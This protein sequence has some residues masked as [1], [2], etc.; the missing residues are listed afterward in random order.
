MLNS[1]PWYFS[2]WIGSRSRAAMTLEERGLYRDI[3][4]LCY[5]SGSV[6]ADERQLRRL[7]GADE[8]EWR[9]AWPAVRARLVVTETGDLTHPRV[10]E[11][12]PVLLSAAAGR[13]KSSSAA[14]KARWNSIRSRVAESAGLDAPR[15]APRIP[16]AE[17]DGCQT[18]C[19]IDAPECGALE[20]RCVAIH[21]PES[22]PDDAG[23]L[24][25]NS[26]KPHPSKGWKSEAFARFWSAVWFKT[27]KRDARRAFETVAADPETAEQI[28]AAAI[29]QG[30]TLKS[31]ADRQGRTVIHPATWLR[32]G[33]WEN[34]A[35]A[36]KT[37]RD[38]GDLPEYNPDW[39][40]GGDE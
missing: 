13:H 28:I 6:P 18:Q 1:Y 25:G 10:Q 19:G 4:D 15:N 30:P 31:E 9:R 16:D 29:A 11:N 32:K 21:I 34:E 36:S 35:P 14:A 23:V 27:D 39:L 7:V 37:A 12:L 40:T 5:Q 2:D 8:D 24:A 33:R 20:L 3:L 17:R 38:P 22:A 26:P